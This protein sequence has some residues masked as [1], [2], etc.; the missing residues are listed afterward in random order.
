MVEIIQTIMLAAPSTHF[1]VMAQAALQ[2][3]GLLSFGHSSCGSQGSPRP[4]YSLAKGAS[5]AFSG[6]MPGLKG[7]NVP[8]RP[9]SSLGGKE[10]CDADQAIHRV[11]ILSC[12]GRDRAI[13][14]AANSVLDRGFSSLPV[15]DNDG[16]SCSASGLTPKHLVLILVVVWRSA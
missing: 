8:E 7:V 12:S 5:A 14:E 6:E 9:A 1:I 2:R 10:I 16:D 13:W 3:R 11:L 4:V 15:A